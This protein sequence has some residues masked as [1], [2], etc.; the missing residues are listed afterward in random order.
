[1]ANK[2]RIR[3]VKLES[4][5]FITL[6]LN[7]L[8]EMAELY[9]ISFAGE[10]WNDDWSNTEQ[11]YKYMKEISGSYNS[12][13]YGLKLDGKLVAMSIG[14]IR[15]WWEGTNYNIE[16]LCVSPELQGQGIGSYFMELIEKDIQTRGAVGIFLQTDNDKPAYSF[17][18]KIGF[19]N[20]GQH[21][22]LYKAL[23]TKIVMA[24]END[25]G[26]ILSLY[27]RQMGAD[28]CPWTEDYPSNETISFDLSRDALFV[29]KEG[30]EIIAAISI[31]HDE[32]V[33]S[34][35]CWNKDMA[36]A[37]ELARLAVLPEKQGH[38]IAK[39][40]LRFGMNIIKDKGCNSIHFIVN[41]YNEKAIRAYAGLGYSV[42]G[43]CHMFE[44]DFLCYEQKL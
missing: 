26:K 14:M 38:G 18:H 27:K 5:E 22:S 10:P 11:L 39:Q 41:K 13:N 43:E 28:C 34:L 29:M 15:H 4:I 31:E 23:S 42:V 9:R 17:Y 21:V 24:T 30:E 33:D 12:L 36:P 3:G 44:Q 35:D 2:K 1:M 25:R 37:G 6:D 16:E 20:L 19:G 7:N 40:M 32:E 8:N